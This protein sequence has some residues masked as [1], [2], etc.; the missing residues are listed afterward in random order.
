MPDIVQQIIARAPSGA[1]VQLTTSPC[2]F[3]FVP[4][5]SN[6]KTSKNF[7]KPQKTSKNFKKR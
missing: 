3:T 7:K 6:E 5:T 4:K 1:V 2:I